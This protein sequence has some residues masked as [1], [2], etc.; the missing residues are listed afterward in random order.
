[1]TLELNFKPGFV[2]D[3]ISQL[4]AILAETRQQNGFIRLDVFRN[5]IEPDKLIIAEL[6]ESSEQ[7]RAYLEWRKQSGLFEKLD[8]ILASKPLIAIWGHL[9]EVTK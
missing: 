2:E 3:F 6:W 1:M 8:A 7:Y 9:L 4:P 5:E